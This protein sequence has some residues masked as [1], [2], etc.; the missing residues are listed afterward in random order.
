MA[1][2]DRLGP[3]WGQRG[4]Q[5]WEAGWRGTGARAPSVQEAGTADAEAAR[6]QNA[7]E[8]EEEE[9][10]GVRT[11]RWRSAD[12]EEEAH[13]RNRCGTAMAARA[14]ALGEPGTGA[15]TQGC[16]ACCSRARGWRWARDVGNEGRGGSAS[17][18]RSSPGRGAGAAF[19]A[20]S[21]PSRMRAS[22]YHT[23]EKSKE[24]KTSALFYRLLVPR[25]LTYMWRPLLQ[26][27]Q[28]DGHLAEH[29]IR[30]TR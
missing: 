11:G 22:R 15:Q 16:P 26:G 3:A 21:A 14:R 9:R 5:G 17:I 8:A 29:L 23:R 7:R 10:E 12:P 25:S 13:D 1:R 20:L 2:G 6:E 19:V 24:V 30:V 4:E 18:F 27:A 28:Q